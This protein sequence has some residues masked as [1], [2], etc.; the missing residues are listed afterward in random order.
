LSLE[1]LGLVGYNASLEMQMLN[2]WLAL[3][4]QAVQLGWEVQNVMALRL[5]RLA[6]GGAADHSE[7]HA[8]VP[9]K[10]AALT[11]THIAGT[12]IAGKGGNGRKVAKKIMSVDKQRIR[13]K[14]RR[15]SE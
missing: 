11:N 7:A 8:M 13:G 6:V 5:M 14:K 2:P 3:S 1:L 10:V 15:L 9:E 12:A 4:F